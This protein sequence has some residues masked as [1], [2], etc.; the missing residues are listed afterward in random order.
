VRRQPEGAAALRLFVV[1]G[2]HVEGFAGLR[3]G[4]WRRRQSRRRCGTEGD[5]Q[6]QNYYDDEAENP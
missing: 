6:S 5:G 4:R 1:N 3:R 2:L